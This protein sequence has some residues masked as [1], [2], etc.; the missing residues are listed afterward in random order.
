VKLFQLIILYSF[1]LIPRDSFADGAPS[2]ITWRRQFEGVEIGRYTQAMPVPL[3]AVVAKI[4]LDS[5][6]V[7]FLVTPS[8]GKDK[9]ESSARSTSEF[10]REAKCQLAVNGAVF[11]PKAMAYGHPVDILGLAISAGEKYSNPNR[12]HIVT[13]G[14]GDVVKIQQPPFEL[15]GVEN[16]LSGYRTILKDGKVIENSKNRHPRT[17]VGLSKN[18][19]ELYL[20]VIDGRK[21]GVTEGATV[22]EAAN[23][24]RSLGA[25]Q[26]LNLD[27]GGSS[28]MVIHDSIDGVRVLNQPSDGFERR[29]ANHLC[30]FAG[31]IH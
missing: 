29:V 20:V 1:A 18:K 15:E 31:E 9:G 26:A 21:P 27:G 11:S 4:D 10:L 24:A 6:M 5:P 19:K 8:N 28:T 12:N 3:K 22:A 16:A 23:F 30:V 14:P 13:F 25:F 2:S 7:R 17:L